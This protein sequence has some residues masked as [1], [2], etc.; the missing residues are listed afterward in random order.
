V[1]EGRIGPLMTAFNKLL[2]TKSREY[3]LPEII[4]A[5]PTDGLWSDGR[6]DED[7]LGMTYPELEAAMWADSV[8][9]CPQDPQDQD[10]LQRYRE[11]RRRN[12]HKMLPSLFLVNLLQSSVIVG[13]PLPQML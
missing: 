3:F 12:L 5:A 6:T 2:V 1:T 13:L 10:R 4:E 8:G 7:Q 11:I 9:H